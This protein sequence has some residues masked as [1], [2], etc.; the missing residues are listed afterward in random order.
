MKNQSTSKKKE[1]WAL[2][3]VIGSGVAFSLLVAAWCLY[4]YSP[5]G[6]YHIKY[7]LLSPDTADE[8]RYQDSDPSTGSKQFFVLDSMLFT[9][10]DKEKSTW[11]TVT[12]DR[13]KYRKFYDALMSDVSLQ[14]G[15]AASIAAKFLSGHPAMLRIMVQSESKG[16]AV[17]K[18]FQEVVFVYDGDYY[19]LEL[20]G[21][22]HQREWAYF[23]HKNIY[24][25]AL[26][27]LK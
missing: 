1:I 20:R 12:V 26:R 4:F 6:L 13:Q 22:S 7:A 24:E 21:D 23:F 11:Q 5:S 3:A 16:K 19:R 8:L 17:T 15:P 27:S 18:I 10:F 2:L 25:I 14:E 9:Y